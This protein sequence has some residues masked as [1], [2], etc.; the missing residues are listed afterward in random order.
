MRNIEPYCLILKDGAWYVYSYCRLRRDFRYF[1][2]ARIV[3]L[4]QGEKFVGRSYEGVDSSVIK[5]DVLKGKEVVDVLLT[6]DP[7]SLSACEEWLGIS[8]CVRLGE[9]YIAQ[10]SLPYDDM[11]INKILSLGSGVRVEKPQRL[12]EAVIERCQRIS[13]MNREV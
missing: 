7:S 13:W 3:R 10:A 9:N 11:L 2:V 6:V 1:K 12:R 5:T 4:E 8:S